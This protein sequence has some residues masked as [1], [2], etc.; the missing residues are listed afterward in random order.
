MKRLIFTV[1]FALALGACGGGGGGPDFR[2]PD[3]LQF[4]FGTPVDVEDN[5]DE[6]Y[7]AENGAN[8]AADVLAFPNAADEATA[9]QLANSLLMSANQMGEDMGALPFLLFPGISLWDDPDCMSVTPGGQITFDRCRMTVSQGGMSGTFSMDGFFDA[10][11]GSVVWDVNWSMNASGPYEG[12]GYATMRFSDHAVGNIVITAGDPTTQL[13][14]S[15][16]SDLSVSMTASGQSAS[17]A[18]TLNADYDQLQYDGAQSCVT[19]GTITLKSL[20][21]EIPYGMGDDYADAGVQFSWIGCGQAQ[22][23]WPVVP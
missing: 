12:L 13:D 10:D 3:T 17:F 1:A 22:V 4:T 15:S 16:R 21:A 9:M 8:G 6:D 18:V 14:G 20:W 2:D 7:A 5:S 23:A 19:G 11:A